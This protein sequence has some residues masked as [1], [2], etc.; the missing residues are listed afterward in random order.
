[1][2][3]IAL[4]KRDTNKKDQIVSFFTAADGGFFVANSHPMHDGSTEN[5]NPLSQIE[6]RIAIATDDDKHKLNKWQCRIQNC[7][8]DHLPWV[9]TNN[10]IQLT[11]L[12]NQRYG[13]MARKN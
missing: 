4:T 8:R 13:E 12:E 3:C 6:H 2:Q 9:T 1:M 11:A 7:Q 5:G 10:S